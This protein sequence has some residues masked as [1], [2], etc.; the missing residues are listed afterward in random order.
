MAGCVIGL[1]GRA[2]PCYF[3]APIA[4]VAKLVD[5]PD[6]GSG[7]FKTVE[8][9]ILSWALEAGVAQIAPPASSFPGPARRRRPPGPGPPPA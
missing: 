3:V 1:T 4:Q 6:S 5:A 2:P 7:G 9:R 8:V